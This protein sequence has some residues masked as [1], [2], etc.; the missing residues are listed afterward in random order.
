M[1]VITSPSCSLPR[2]KKAQTYK[3][4]QCNIQKLNT[5]SSTTSFEKTE[6][7]LHLEKNLFLDNLVNGKSDCSA[8]RNNV[9]SSTKRDE[10]VLI[11]SKEELTVATSTLSSSSSSFSPTWSKCVDPVDPRYPNYV[12]E[13]ERSLPEHHVN[14][15]QDDMD[16]PHLKRKKLILLTHPEVTSLFGY[17]PKSKYILCGLLLIQ[18]A[19][20]YFFAHPSF[21]SHW[22]TE[23]YWTCFLV[24]AYF[25]GGTI[26][27]T[28]GVLI[29]EC[30]HGLVAKS[31]TENRVW[32]F[33]ANLGIPFPI[34]A[35]FRRYHL[36][37]HAFQGVIG[38][39][40]DLPLSMEWSLI[41]SNGLGKT[42]W[43]FCFPFFYLLRGIWMLKPPQSLELWNAGWTVMADFVL[44]FGI[45]PMAFWY[46]VASIWFGYGLHP[47]AAHFIQEHYT[48]VSGQETYSYYGVLNRLLL[49]VGYH[50]E[51]HDF[52]QIPWTKLPTLFSMANEFYAPLMA[53]QSWVK[54]ILDFIFHKDLGPQ[55]RVAR[56]MEDHKRGRSTIKYMLAP[57][58]SD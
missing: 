27:A 58:K 57:V 48:F 52:T 51:H 16:E 39:D 20:G 2:T 56:N 50:N 25:I 38:K 44:Y 42:V 41:Q 12:G 23:L 18:Y 45:G 43:V 35:S 22:S 40:P 4:V 36:D 6:V 31:W 34:Y 9:T 28:L 53:H 11:Q 15:A 47:G 17:E 3:Q 5:Q 32:G 10:G 7:H 37:H 33:V 19:I 24:V 26:T 29:H 55:S 8:T 1:T 46:L 21:T 30:T 14:L 13:W 49:N 54:V